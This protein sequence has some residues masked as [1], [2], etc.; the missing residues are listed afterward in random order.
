MGILFNVASLNSTS[1]AT[2]MAT[3]ALRRYE[4][5]RRPTFHGVYSIQGLFERLQEEEM[6]TVSA[7]AAL[8]QFGPGGPSTAS[9]DQLRGQS[10]KC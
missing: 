6:R 8:A 5:C 1:W 2:A 4:L 9:G 10:A 3:G 7:A